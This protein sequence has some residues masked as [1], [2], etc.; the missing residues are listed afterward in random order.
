MLVGVVFVLL[1]ILSPIHQAISA[2]LGSRTAAWLYDELT[3]ATVE[4]PGMGHLE[5][6]KLTNDLSMARDFDM[7]MTGP[8]L[9]ISMDWASRCGPPSG[10]QKMARSLLV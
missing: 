1:Q 5:H 10:A 8:P 6:P 4:P 7:G 3:E 9:A 2:N